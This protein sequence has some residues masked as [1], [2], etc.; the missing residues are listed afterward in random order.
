MKKWIKNWWF[1]ILMFVCAI[2][3]TLWVVIGYFILASDDDF[4]YT[5]LIINSISPVLLLII[6]G[7]A[8]MPKGE[9]Q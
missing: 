1:S 2:G 9:Q 8:N 5:L 3:I 6:I 4:I 7:V